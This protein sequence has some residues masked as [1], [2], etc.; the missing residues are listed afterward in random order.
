MGTSQFLVYIK[1]V[2]ILELLLDNSWYYYVAM[3]TL[4]AGSKGFYWPRCKAGHNRYHGNTV[5]DMVQ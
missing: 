2:T 1:I 5:R 3:V 4:P